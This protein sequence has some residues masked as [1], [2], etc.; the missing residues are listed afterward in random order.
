[1]GF[2]VIMIFLIIAIIF[3]SVALVSGSGESV[4]TDQHNEPSSPSQEEL[5]EE[6]FDDF[7]DT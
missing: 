4:A 2:L 5:E 3:L 7:E 1:M 6:F